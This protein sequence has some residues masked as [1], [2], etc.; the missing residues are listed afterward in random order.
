MTELKDKLRIAREARGVSQ[1]ELSKLT[2]LKQPHIARIESGGC[3]ITS[4][5]LERI[6]KALHCTI[7]IVDE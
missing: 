4:I 7:A 3:A 5:T 1:N 6:L 2:G